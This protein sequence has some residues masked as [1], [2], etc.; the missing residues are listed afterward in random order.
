MALG[1]KYKEPDI[2]FLKHPGVSM[3]GLRQIME[4]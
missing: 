3:K 2:A 4:I 1:S